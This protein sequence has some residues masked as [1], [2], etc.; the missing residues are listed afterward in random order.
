MLWGGVWCG[1]GLVHPFCRFTPLR[2]HPHAVLVHPCCCFTPL[3]VGLV[4]LGLVLMSF[5]VCFHM[6][7]ASEYVCLQFHRCVKA[8]YLYIVSFV[9]VG[10]R[11][12]L[13]CLRTIGALI[14]ALAFEFVTLHDIVSF[15]FTCVRCMLRYM[16]LSST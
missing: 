12:N 9:L 11:F 1:V 13:M 4:G 14:M 10:V 6:D 5:A 15:R 2:S 16:M 8:A 3:F 7:I